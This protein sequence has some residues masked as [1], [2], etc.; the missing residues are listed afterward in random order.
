MYLEIFENLMGGFS[1]ADNILID[2]MILAIAAKVYHSII[3]SLVGMQYKNG[4]ITT[5][6]QGKIMY[7]LVFLL[8][9]PIAYLTLAIIRFVV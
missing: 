5:S 6:N 8:G 2:M 4:T 9:L 7:L 1:L 3:F